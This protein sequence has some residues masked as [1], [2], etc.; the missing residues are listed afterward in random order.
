MCLRLMQASSGRPDS[1]SD[2]DGSAAARRAGPGPGA[3]G[4]SLRLAV[5][6][7]DSDCRWPGTRP[8]ASTVTEPE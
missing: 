1:L 4:Q 6:V 2:S 8:R 7:T 3:E 5:P